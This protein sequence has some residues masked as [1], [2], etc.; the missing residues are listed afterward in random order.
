M[1]HGY[2]RDQDRATRQDNTQA[3]AF[4]D[5]DGTLVGSTIVNYYVYFKT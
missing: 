1:P 3:A 4:F 5:V 2:S